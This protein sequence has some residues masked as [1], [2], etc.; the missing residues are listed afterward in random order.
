MKKSILVINT[1]IS[2]ILFSCQKPIDENKIASDA[3][4]AYKE[5]QTIEA[6]KM[7]TIAQQFYNQLSNPNDPQTDA[8]SKNYMD[9]NW[10]STPEPIGG[11][12]RVGF[13]KTLS[14]FGAMITDL[15]WEPQ[16]MLVSGN[17]IIVRSIAT[18]T[19]NSPEGYFF[20]TPT[21]GSKRFEIPTIDIHTI[22][23]GKI[24]ESH[25]V[26]AWLTALGQINEK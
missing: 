8:L 24:T 23:N 14:V 25:H 7:E 10:V 16:E 5:K 15:K 21:N 3:V 19:P 17:K 6:D 13:V 12:G 18:G 4:E 2:V 1:L 22:E 9:E 11:A 20:G 26:E